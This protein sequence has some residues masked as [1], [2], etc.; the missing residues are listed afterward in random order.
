M[1]PVT[2]HWA[3]NCREKSRNSQ[4][5]NWLAQT[6]RHLVRMRDQSVDFPREE[7]ARASRIL[8]GPRPVDL[9]PL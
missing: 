2:T 1:A 8:N 3:V 6:T 5:G 7:G 9:A 4:M